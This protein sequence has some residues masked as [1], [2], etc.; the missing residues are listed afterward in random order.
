[1]FCYTFFE[2]FDKIF[3]KTV[4]SGFL[5]ENLDFQAE[6]T[7][8]GDCAAAEGR[9]NRELRIEDIKKLG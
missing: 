2:E 9:E 5:A 7:A 3:V 1:M 4:N 8:G 6:W